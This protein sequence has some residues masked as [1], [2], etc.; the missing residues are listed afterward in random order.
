MAK[1]K[2]NIYKDCKVICACGATFDTKSTKDEMYLKKYIN[3]LRENPNLPNK[4]Q[5]YLREI[6]NDKTVLDVIVEKNLIISYDTGTFLA[7]DIDLIDIYLKHNDTTVLIYAKE[8][9]AN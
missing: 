3:L 5:L 1:E 8:E 6:S 2:L 7:S 4:K 9:I